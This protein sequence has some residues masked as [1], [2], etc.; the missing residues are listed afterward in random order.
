MV[1]DT[2]F[3]TV[4]TIAIF[5]VVFIHT[6]RYVGVG[7]ETSAIY[8]SMQL[9]CMPLF[10][11]ISGYFSSLHKPFKEICL[12]AIDFIVTYLLFSVIWMVIKHTYSISAFIIPS[13]TLW[14]ILSLPCWI[15][16]AK[17]LLNHLSCIYLLCISVVGGVLFG[18]VPIGN[19]M[20]IQRTIAFFP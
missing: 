3:D 12:R 6:L 1:R 20:S 15:V 16:L 14:F 10:I 4:K 13:R 17:I 9:V 5:M 18:F 8:N 7:Y 11:F 2:Y 19:E